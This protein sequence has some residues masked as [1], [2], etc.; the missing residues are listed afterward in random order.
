ML[1][2]L[3]HER[4]FAFV[5]VALLAATL[6]VLVAFILVTQTG[7]QPL[8][9]TA[10]GVPHTV[11]ARRPSAAM[12]APDSVW[13]EPLV[14]NAPI[15]RSSDHLIRALDHEVTSERSRNIG[16]WIATN[17][18]STPLYNVPASQPRVH[19]ELDAPAVPGRAALQAA[20]D[21]VPIPPMATPAAGPDGHMTIWQPATDTLWEFFKAARLPNGWH[22]KWGGA[23]RAVSHSPGYYGPG[24]WPG[25]T[26]N[27]GATATSLSVL[28]GVILLRDIRSGTINHALALNLPAPRA[29]VFAWPAQRSDGVGGSDSLPEGARIRL[30]PRLDLNHLSLPP[31]TRM[32]AE[33]AQRYGMIVRDQ[34]GHGISLFAQDPTPAGRTTYYGRD[35]AF[36]GLSPSELL[37]SFPWDHLQVLRLHLCMRAPCRQ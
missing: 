20:F 32:V 37:A 3:R 36:D 27:W 34:T 35:G 4:R 33:A 26:P 17:L 29:G 13:N 19:V 14:A 22:A 15:D 8:P 9:K 28:G 30:D 24:S 6:L 2:S 7:E 1:T 18:G 25:A 23:I 11:P 12:F 21:A 5:A 31:F 10:R 16:P